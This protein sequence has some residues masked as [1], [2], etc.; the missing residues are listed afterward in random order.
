MA[1]SNDAFS[2]QTAPIP[3]NSRPFAGTSAWA[4]GFFACIPIPLLSSIVVGIIMLVVSLSQRKKGGVAAQNGVNAANWGVLQLAIPLLFFATM[5]VGLLTGE[6]T[7]TGVRMHGG[8]K[9]ALLAIGILW[10]LTSVVHLVV[11]I[12]GTIKARNGETFRALAP[13][14]FKAT[15]K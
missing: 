1:N 8:M 14:I 7:E 4:S 3:T 9:A 5:T 2:P 6:K 10:L 15:K 13:Q 12:I 11:T